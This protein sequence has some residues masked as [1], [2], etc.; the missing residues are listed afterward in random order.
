MR[1]LLPVTHVAAHGRDVRRQLH[2]HHG[3]LVP[4]EIGAPPFDAVI[5]VGDGVSVMRLHRIRIFPARTLCARI[6]R[7]SGRVAG[8]GSR[9][10]TL[11][12]MSQ[13]A[14]RSGTMTGLMQLSTLP[15]NTRYASEISSSGKRWVTIS[16]GRMR[17]ASTCSNRRG[18]C[19]FTGHW[20][21]RSVSPLFMT[22]P[23]GTM[24][25]GGP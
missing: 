3:T 9:H 24:L 7:H 10:V 1:R 19:R 20:L 6:A 15:V 13:A 22:L 25:S 14:R 5:V 18:S 2:G 4:I 16:P 17:P 23:S 8:I 12:R 11:L 21:L